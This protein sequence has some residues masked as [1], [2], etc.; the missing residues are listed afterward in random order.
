MAMVEAVKEC[1]AVESDEEQTAQQH[2][3]QTVTPRHKHS[4]AS[5]RG[6]E[7]HASSAE[8]HASPRDGEATW[9][10]RLEEL[11]AGGNA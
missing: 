4:G 7:Q 6:V 10:K 1:P 9:S 2:G 11:C 8:R 5:V 3:N